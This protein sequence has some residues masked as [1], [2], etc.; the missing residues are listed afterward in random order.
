MVKEHGLAPDRISL[1]DPDAPLR[2]LS[3]ADQSVRMISQLMK[4]LTTPNHYSTTGRKPR[5][6]D[7]RSTGGKP[8]TTPDAVKGAVGAGGGGTGGGVVGAGAGAGAG[9]SGVLGT[10]RETNG[11][12]GGLAHDGASVEGGGRIEDNAEPGQREDAFPTERHTIATAGGPPSEIDELF[13][14]Q[15]GPTPTTGR[16]S[17]LSDGGRRSSGEEWARGGSGGG[18]QQTPASPAATRKAAADRGRQRVCR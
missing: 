9:G 4:R 8:A 12:H 16:A 14:G 1:L 3:K 18:R 7:G 5:K 2:H 13:G 6:G 15:P 10:G 11:A 17:D